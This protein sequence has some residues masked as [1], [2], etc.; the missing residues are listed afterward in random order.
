MG[1]GAAGRSLSADAAS[2]AVVEQLRSPTKDFAVVA[3]GPSTACSVSSHSELPSDGGY[4]DSFAFLVGGVGSRGDSY[5]GRGRGES[6]DTMAGA[7]AECS[8]TN[9]NTVPHQVRATEAGRWQQGRAFSAQVDGA[10]LPMPKGS[11]R[12]AGAQ[13]VRRRWS[14]KG[15]RRRRTFSCEAVAMCGYLDDCSPAPAPSASQTT[16][17]ARGRP[18]ALSEVEQP[19]SAPL[20][21]QPSPKSVLEEAEPSIF[22]FSSGEYGFFWLGLTSPSQSNEVELEMAKTEAREREE[23]AV[24]TAPVPLEKLDTY[25]SIRENQI[26]RVEARELQSWQ[27]CNILDELERSQM[28]Y[29]SY[30]WNSD[31]LPES[32]GMSLYGLEELSNS[33]SDESCD[34]G[35]VSPAE[36]Y[37]SGTAEDVL[38]MIAECN[39]PVVDSPKWEALGVSSQHCTSDDESSIATSSDEDRLVEDRAPPVEDP[40]AGRRRKSVNPLFTAPTLQ[41]RTTKKPSNKFI[42]FLKGLFGGKDSHPRPGAASAATSRRKTHLPSNQRRHSSK[43]QAATRHTEKSLLSLTESHRGRDKLACGHEPVQAKGGAIVLPPAIFPSYSNRQKQEQHF[44][45]C[46][47]SASTPYRGSL[48]PL[49]SEYQELP[50]RT[51]SEKE[52]KPS[53]SSHRQHFKLD[54]FCVDS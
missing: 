39:F 32:E 52:K 47:A 44:P 40:L 2:I 15:G 51:A 1:Y 30:I 21:P 48:N 7:R 3:V 43:R 29:L 36:S 17:D 53:P 19:S 24:T 25:V 12:A 23:A 38:R 49:H 50:C 22:N 11:S 41:R 33:K 4:T 14:E 10:F 34:D 42:A 9:S 16:G 54:F 45:P 13:R 37:K 8:S 28:L 6:P 46:S 20:P 18:A 27:N 35:Q 31:S 26:E 5:R